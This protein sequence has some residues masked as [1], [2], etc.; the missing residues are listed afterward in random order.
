MNETS[1]QNKIRLAVSR[2]GGALALR[3]N[4]G[5]FKTFDGRTVQAGMG[6][7]TSDL[8]GIVSHVVTPADIGRTVGV[9]LAMEVKTDIGRARIEQSAFLTRIADLGGLGGIV[10]SDDDA[11]SLLAEKWA[12]PV[13][14]KATEREPR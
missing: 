11:I 8:I 13:A 6:K 9:F 1:I 14:W 3:N 5:L 7:G 10:R 4:T 12:S 2:H